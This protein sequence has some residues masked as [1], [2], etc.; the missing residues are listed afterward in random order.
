MSIDHEFRLPVATFLS[1]SRCKAVYTYIL[2]SSM[3]IQVNDDCGKAPRGLTMACVPSE[4]HG[5]G[6]CTSDHAVLL[7]DSVFQFFNVSREKSRDFG[8][9]LAKNKTCI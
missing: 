9:I 3:Y 2:Y 5:E 1:L 8:F 4:V 6:V 7:P